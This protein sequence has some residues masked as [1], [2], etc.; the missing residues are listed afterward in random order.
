MNEMSVANQ[1]LRPSLS[2]RLVR[3]FLCHDWTIVFEADGYRYS[4]Q[5]FINNGT[6]HV[7]HG[8]F[9]PDGETM[10]APFNPYQAAERDVFIVWVHAGCPPAEP[11]DLEY[12]ELDALFVIR[13]V[14]H[15][16]DIQVG[17]WDAM[18]VMMRI[19]HN[20]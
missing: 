1:T 20:G 19:T 16:Y 3:W 12:L 7:L 18:A 11:F 14:Q 10:F 4:P 6:Y 2:Q 17:D 13:A 5:R 9:A 15:D 8:V